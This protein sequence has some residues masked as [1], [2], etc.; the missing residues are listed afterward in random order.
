MIWKYLVAAFLVIVFATA[1]KNKKQDVTA[2]ADVYYTCSMHPQIMQDKPGTCSICHM[3]LIAV[4]KS[5][6]PNDEI[7][8]S[9]EQVQLGNIQTDTLGH[10]V[11]GDK[12]VLTATLNV[13]EMKVNTVSARITG[14]I[15]R[16]YFKN[17]GELVK[18]GDHLFDLYSEEL[19]NAKQEYMVALKRQQ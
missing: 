7:T 16:L 4:N 17:T 10:G 8:L 5:S 14:R 3:E 11:M 19:N 9:D 2:K 15:D 18:K 1:C 6:Q 12:V 13:D